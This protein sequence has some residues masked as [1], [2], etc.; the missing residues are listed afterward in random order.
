M[1]VHKEVSYKV[2]PPRNFAVKLILDVAIC[3]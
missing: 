1:F 3:Y 2:Y